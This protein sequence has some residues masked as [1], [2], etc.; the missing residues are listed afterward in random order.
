[1]RGFKNIVFVSAINKLRLF[2]KDKNKKP[3]YAERKALSIQFTKSLLEIGQLNKNWIS[4]VT[5]HTKK[6]DLADSFLQGIWYLNNDNYL[7][8]SLFEKFI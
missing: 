5:A 4:F 3:K 6:D 8:D 7:E 1:M 2:I